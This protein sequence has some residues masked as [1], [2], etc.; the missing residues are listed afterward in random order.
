MRKWSPLIAVS[1]G[2]F[3]LLVDV[4]IVTVALPAI[5]GDLHSSLSDLQWVLDGYALTLAA[6]LLGAGS[7]ADRYGRRRTYLVGLVVF[8]LASAACAAA[9]SATAL[10]VSRL[11][12]GAGAAAMF[13]TTV[14]LLNVAYRGRDRGVA[15]GV[16]GAVNGAAAAAGPIVGGLLTEYLNWRWIFLINLP[17]A[18]VAL[19]FTVRGVPE[20]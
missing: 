16:W 14:A 5:A 18:V 19:I 13:A 15:F 7:A 11:A 4:T 12:Q 3:M 1:L 9:S 2:T 10:I 17:V 20:S 8:T 6:L